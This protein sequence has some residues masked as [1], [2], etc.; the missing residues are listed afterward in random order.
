MK[1]RARRFL[2]IVT[3]SLMCAGWV[4]QA[5]AAMASPDP[6]ESKVSA[7]LAEHPGGTQVAPGVVSWNSGAVV[8]T[9][10]GAVSPQAIGNCATGQYCAWSGTSYSGT[11]L[12]FTACSASGTS[13]SLALLSGLARSTA[14]ARTSGHV[15]AVSGST[16]IYSMPANTG[17]PANSATL[18]KLVCYT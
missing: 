10:D 7:I 6:L 3:A 2:A 9:L 8:L 17:K 4:L 5:T 16:L 12:A 14:N 1:R 18:S 15:N 13:S 11:K